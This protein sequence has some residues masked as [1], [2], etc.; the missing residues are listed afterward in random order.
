[1]FVCVCL[2]VVWCVCVG[3][4]VCVWCVCMCGGCVCVVWCLLIVIQN[5]GACAVLYYLWPFRL[6]HIPHYLTYNKNLVERKSIEQEIR[7][8]IFSRTLYV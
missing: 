7:D 2:C 6:Y 5:A 4:C 8:L 3:V 1:V